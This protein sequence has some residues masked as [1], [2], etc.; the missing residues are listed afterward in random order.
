MGPLFVVLLWIMVGGTFSIVGGFAF[1]L[2]ARW[3]L[4]GIPVG[5]E[6]ASIIAGALPLA[7]FAYLFGCVLV[8]SVWSG[9]RGRDWGW[10]DTWDTPILGN[11]HLAMIDVTDQGMVCYQPI[12]NAMADAGPSIADGVRRLEVRP[13]YLIGAAAPNTITEYPHTSP[14]TLFFMV[15]TRSGARRDFKTLAALDSAAQQLGGP[16]RLESVNTIYNRY[17]YQLIDLIPVCLLAI[18]PL[19]G[20]IFL[21]RAF[22][23]LRATRELAARS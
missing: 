19:I 8:F 3:L 1:W 21:F 13:P 18:P 7:G 10:G 17:R 23:R 14:E 5:L 6:R 15:D 11:Y 22:L 12:R 4:L 20:F 9:A 16:L 2:L